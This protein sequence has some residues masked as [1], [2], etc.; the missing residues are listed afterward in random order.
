MTPHTI[1]AL[2]ALYAAKLRAGGISPQR[3]DPTCSFGEVTQ[4]DVLA[5][6]LY[7][8][9]QLPTFVHQEDSLGKANRH[10]TAIQMC[11]SFARVYTLNELMAHNR[12]LLLK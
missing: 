10:L 7:L 9:E 11:L 2:A 4:S 5:H 12:P 8:S 1:E 6:A 3:I